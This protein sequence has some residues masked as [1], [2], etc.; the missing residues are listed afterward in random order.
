MVASADPV[1]ID[2]I[3][4]NLVPKAKTAEV[5]SKPDHYSGAVV[6]PEKVTYG[7]VE[8]HVKRIGDF[9]FAYCDY[10]TSVTI[11]KSIIEIGEAAFYASRKLSSVYISDIESW[12]NIN[13]II[14]TDRSTYPYY[15]ESTDPLYYGAKLYLNNEE[16]REL[17]IPNN[18]T[19][20]RRRAFYGCSAMTSLIIPNSVTSIESYAFSG[21]SS[22]TS[23]TIPNSVTSIGGSAFSGCTG[24]TSI[25]IPNSVTSITSAFRDCSSLTSIT[26]PNS[27][28]SIGD[29]AFSGCTSLTS[30]TIPNSVTSIGVQAFYDCKGLTSII[31]PNSV[32]SIGDY[33]FYGC[34]GLTSVTIPNSVTSIGVEAFRDC[35]SLTSITIPNSVTSIGNDAF[36][37]CS[38]LTSITIPNSVTSIGGSA[39][40]GCSGLKT[41]TI[42][43]GIETIRYQAFANCHELTDVYC[44]AENVPRMLGNYNELVTDAFNGSYI[45]FTTLHVPDESLQAYKETEPWSQFGTIVGLSG[46]T[47]ETPKCATPSIS[48]GGKKLMF[49][50]DT[51]DVEFVTEIKDADIG[52]FFDDRINLT[53]TYEISVYATKAGY[54]NSNVATATL[55]WGS[56][57][58]TDTTPATAIEMVPA[59]EAAMPVLIQNNGGLLTVQG[60]QDGTPVSVYTIAGTEAG[61]AVSQNS[62]ATI[63]TSMQ[64]GDIAIVRIGNRSVKVVLK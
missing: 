26:I 9:A 32:T 36:Y 34:S 42:G 33:A 61:S 44:Y 19:T 43:K 10:L 35:S 63:S 51:E 21:C 15:G 2:G 5:K 46:G 12:C 39:F 52:K 28:T 58:F 37:G 41:I 13:L 50:C 16:I 57:T 56:A 14:T 47:L 27:V 30:I 60:A 18:V 25:I 53:A 24:L 55:V 22:L 17:I 1:E 40:Y 38:G 59:M 3:Y 45:E 8:Y 54:D 23:I 64:Q 7:G 11:P 62:R 29:C 31:I 20:I 48:Y 49:V 4:Y 6:I